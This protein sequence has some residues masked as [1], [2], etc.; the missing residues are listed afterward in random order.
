MEQ[1]RQC[2]EEQ[3][4]ALRTLEE[5]YTRR[6]AE[7]IQ[8]RARASAQ[9]RESEKASSGHQR[10][11]ELLRKTA[12]QLKQQ[13]QHLQELLAT[14]E[15]EHLRERE[16]CKPLDGREVQNVV[17]REVEKERAKM[18]GVV[19][20]HK[21]R[22]AEQQKAYQNLED[23]FRM[24][25]RIEAERYHELQRTYQEVAGE[26]EACRQTAISA[27]RKEQ[28]A[29]GM[30]AEL[31]AMVKE[32]KGRITELSRGKQ[33]AIGQLKVVGVTGERTTPRHQTIS[34]QI[35]CVPG[36]YVFALISAF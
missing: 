32:Q 31:T 36:H 23:E 4:K 27:V 28:R 3:R 16:R 18:E 35:A 14:R 25:L 8:E 20:Q 24:A 10:E 17:A 13:L 12:R 21:Q 29:T 15:R 34:G 2:G 6:D 33:E 9:L 1:L 19:D 5:S 22:V 30:V 11:A 7:Q 26:V